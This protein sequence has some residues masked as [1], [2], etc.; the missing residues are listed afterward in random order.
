MLVLTIDQRGSSTDDDRVADV[1]RLLNHADHATGRVRDFERTAGDEVQGLLDDPELAVR[2][3]LALVRDGH[4]TVGIGAGPVRRPLPPSA[5]AGA[6]PAYQHARTAVERGKSSQDRLAVEGPDEA[7]AL[8]AEAVLTLL[9]AVVQRR[10]PAGWEA[11]D[12]VAD[13]LTQTEAADRLDIS[14]QALSQRLQVGLWPHEVRVRP[15]AAGLLALA[16]TAA[17]L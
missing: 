15:V 8:Q 1:L 6:G 7:A 2:L 12:L 17:E 4:W 3:T 14:K 11:A 13:G 5:R 10:S 9:S 16:D